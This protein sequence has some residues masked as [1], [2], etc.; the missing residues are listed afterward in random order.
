MPSG[1]ELCL[2]D[3][4]GRHERQRIALRERTDDIWHCYLP[5]ARPGH[6]LRLSRARALQARGRTPLQPHKLLLD[7]YAKDLIGALRWSDALYG[8]T[9]GSKR[10][11][12]SFD[13]RDSAP[14]MPKCRVLEA[15]FTWGDGPPP[16][17][18]LAGHGD[19][20][21][22]RARLHD[23]ASRRFPR[24]CAAPT[25]AWTAHRSSTTCSAW[26]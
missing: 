16:R 1:V 8:Y 17:D 14:F 20:R 10:N 2:F 12:L 25:R 24:R 7:P 26:A 21:D 23:D 3:D 6:G 22:A 11:D 5:Q 4:N 15:A 18:P 19:L 13:R 9:V